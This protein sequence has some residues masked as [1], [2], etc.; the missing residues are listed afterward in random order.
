[1]KKLKGIGMALTLLV[2][3]AGCE[4]FQDQTPENISLR[5]TGSAGTQV[6]VIYSKQFV[7]GVD[8]LGVTQVEVFGSDTVFHV[9]P[10]DTIINIALEQ[11]FFVQIETMP[12]DTISVDVRVDVDGRNVVDRSGGIFPGVPWRYVYQF[13]QALTSVIEVII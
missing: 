3:V 10:I 7:A 4:V 13:N 5:V 2:A 9:L 6:M 11:R 8:Q 1:M 12:T